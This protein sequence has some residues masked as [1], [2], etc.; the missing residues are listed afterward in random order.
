MTEPAARGRVARMLRVA[1][2]AVREIRPAATLALLFTVAS[3]GVIIPVLRLLVEQSGH[4]TGAAAVFTAAHVAGGVVG[5]AFG[6]RAR[7]PPGSAA[8]RARVLL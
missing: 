4:G 7:A 2:N 1:G 3:T 8:P 6:S 5:A